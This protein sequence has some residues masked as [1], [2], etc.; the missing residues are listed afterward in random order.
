VR[1]GEGTVSTVGSWLV[2]SERW[3]CES[4]GRE[5]EEAGGVPEANGAEVA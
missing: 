1:G 2:G 3:S 4:Q 5:E